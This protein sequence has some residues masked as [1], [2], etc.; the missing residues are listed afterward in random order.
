MYIDQQNDKGRKTLFSLVGDIEN[1]ELKN[2]LKNTHF[3]PNSITNAKNKDFALPGRRKFPVNTP[4]NAILSKAY[5]EY[6]K[7]S[8]P[9]TEAKQIAK[10]L[11]TG[12]ALHK[13][14]ADQFVY[15]Q[16]EAQAPE[17]L[18]E[19][20]TPM[21][22]L[23]E[24]DFCKVANAQ[25]LTMAQKM[26]DAGSANLC[27]ADRVEFSKNFV[28]AAEDLGFNIKSEGILKHAGTLDFDAV[29][30][31]YALELRS[32]LANRKGNATGQYIKL[33][34]SLQQCEDTPTPEDLH[35]LAGV[36]T[37]LDSLAGITEKD[38]DKG[39]G[40]P[41]DA[42]FV[43]KE[44][45]TEGSDLPQLPDADTS[46]KGMS[47]ADIVGQYGEDVLEIVEQPD[48]KVDYDA[49]KNV[50]RLSKGLGASPA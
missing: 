16:K 46:L 45:S 26:F 4:E 37:D 40:T 14:A 15:K 7:D 35:K 41:Y 49:L 33:A 31:A 32:G 48:G 19:L 17:K 23:P 11:N 10:T 27:L 29:H 24:Y 6:Q 2:K 28:K 5:F 39:L 21:T 36:I 38:Y 18:P 47:K 9:Q 12:L 8:I 1:T 22:L 34:E 3:D 43:Q 44:A 13:V 20:E 42:V 30:T 25:D 50:M